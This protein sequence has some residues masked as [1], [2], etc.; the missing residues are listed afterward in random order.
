MFADFSEKAA[1][2]SDPA[3]RALMLRV[4]DELS[5]YSAGDRILTDD[6]APVV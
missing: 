3:L 5:P 1:A 2:L 4:T 6:R